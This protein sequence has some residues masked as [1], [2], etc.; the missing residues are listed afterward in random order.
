MI[1]NMSVETLNSILTK[2]QSSFIISNDIFDVIYEYW[3]IIFLFIF[4]FIFF[5]YY[6]NRK[7]RKEIEKLLKT[8]LLTKTMSQDSIKDIFNKLI[9][10]ANFGEYELISFDIDF[11]KMI[12][13]YRGDEVG[14]EVLVIIAEQLKAALNDSDSYISRIKSDNFIILRKAN[15]NMSVN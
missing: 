8:D 11:F 12:N 10:Y 2:E 1:K 3:F 13:T 5:F 14:N 15:S 6:Q 4:I 9:P 7:K